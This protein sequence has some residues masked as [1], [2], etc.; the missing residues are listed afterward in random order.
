M[1]RTVNL[2]LFLILGFGAIT[3][4]A[5][6]DSGGL[7]TINPNQD[8]FATIHLQTHK[9][10]PRFG[11]F[12]NYLPART[13]AT[14]TSY[15]PEIR[16]KIKTVRTGLSN[17]SLMVRLKYL[18]PLMADLDTERLTPMAGN[19]TKAHRNSVFL[20][21]FLRTR[22]ASSICHAEVCQNLGKGRNEFE[23]LR[24]YKAFTSKYLGP[25]QE[26]A[27]TFFEDD[28]VV[29]YHVSSVSFGRQYDFERKGY[30]VSH[31]FGMNN[32]F[33]MGKA[34]DMRIVFE[35]KAPYENNL[36][37][38]LGRGNAL[39]FLLKMDE[40]TAERYQTEGITTLYLVKKIK[41]QH[42]GKAIDNAA[43]P[44]EFKYA[45]E[46][47]EIEIYEDL[48]LTKP[49]SALSLNDLILKTP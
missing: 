44:I 38:K 19:S 12:D 46:S 10:L 34:R 13:K 36:K 30:W 49:L 7:M 22:L 3:T 37:N 35:P 41:V 18:A 24:N 9:D 43:Q 48:A 16:E 25:L 21:S 32:V 6:Q 8:D 14:R 11:V 31:S 15:S 33:S 4:L 26:W 29:G 17:Y 20:Q 42:A 5:A 28:Q 1:K 45:H 27:K 23:R 47:P 40:E 39:Q 2:C